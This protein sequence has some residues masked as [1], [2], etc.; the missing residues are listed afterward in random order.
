MADLQESDATFLALIWEVASH[1]MRDVGQDP[2]GPTVETAQFLESVR[3]IQGW[4]FDRLAATQP[5][6]EPMRVMFEQLAQGVRGVPEIDL[7][8][9]EPGASGG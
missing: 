8:L 6:G 5:V 9:G 1:E 7:W 2:E 3:R 4:T